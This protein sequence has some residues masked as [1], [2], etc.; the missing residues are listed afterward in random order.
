MNLHI[1]ICEVKLRASWV[2]S[3]KEKRMVVRRIIERLRHKFNISIADIDDLDNHQ[4]IVIGIT[5][6]S[7]S[8]RM[9]EQILDETIKCMEELTEAEILNIDIE[10]LS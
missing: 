7:N 10:V 5:C 9:T 3:L 1:G 6:V 4:S 8:K 2:H